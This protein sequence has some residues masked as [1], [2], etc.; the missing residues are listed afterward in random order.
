MHYGI[1]RAFL[2]IRDHFVARPD[3]SVFYY[4]AEDDNDKI[5][6]RIFAGMVGDDVVARITQKIKEVPEAVRAARYA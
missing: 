4:S 5:G 6:L 2:Q 1:D 3:K